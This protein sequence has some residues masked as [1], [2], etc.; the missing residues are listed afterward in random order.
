MTLSSR[1]GVVLS[2]PRTRRNL[3]YLGLWLSVASALTPAPV[4]LRPVPLAD[5]PRILVCTNR[6][7]RKAGSHDTLRLLRGLTSTTAVSADDAMSQIDSCGCLGG[8]GKGPNVVAEASGEVFWDVYKPKSASALLEAVLGLEVADEAVKASVHRMYAERAMRANKLDE[9]LALL[10]TALN[11]AGSLRLQGAVLLSELLHLRADVHSLK[12]D[13]A[14][15]AADRERAEGILLRRR[16]EAA[17]EGG[18]AV[19]GC[20]VES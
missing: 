10:T 9:A 17:C 3:I 12:G 4:P 15:A 19:E 20:E 16:V 8:C 5:R 14:A 1:S 13:S 2:V 6:A 7:C 11:T 18:L